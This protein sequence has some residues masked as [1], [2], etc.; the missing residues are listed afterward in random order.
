MGGG[1]KRS[2]CLSCRNGEEP[3]KKSETSLQMWVFYTRRD[4]SNSS[5]QQCISVV[6]Y[7]AWLSVTRD[8]EQHLRVA[9]AM[10]CHRN[11][12]AGIVTRTRS[13]QQE[14]WFEFRLGSGAFPLPKS[15]QTVSGAHPASCSMGIGVLSLRVKRLGREVVQSP[16][17]SAEV[18]KEWSYTSVLQMALCFAQPQPL[19]V[20]CDEMELDKFFFNRRLFTKYLYDYIYIWYFGTVTI[21]MVF[22]DSYNANGYNGLVWGSVINQVT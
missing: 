1:G 4:R 21:Y 6:Q 12:V 15:V 8:R 7:T 20:M 9:Y 13:A 11:R 2:C 16:W 3:Q 22:R 5:T 17:C 14:L 18:K 19:L 10:K